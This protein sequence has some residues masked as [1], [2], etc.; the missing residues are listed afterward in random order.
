MLRLGCGQLQVS[1]ELPEAVA[2]KQSKETDLEVGRWGE[3]LVYRFLLQ[4]QKDSSNWAVDWINEAFNTGTPY[5]IHL[6][7]G[8]P[9]TGCLCRMCKHMARKTVMLVSSDACKTISPGTWPCRK[10]AMHELVC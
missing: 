6:R 4:C 2:S 1:T 5:D 9:L 8:C 3:E 10:W 7:Q